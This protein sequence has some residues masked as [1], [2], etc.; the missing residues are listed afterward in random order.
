MTSGE[1]LPR[2]TG[3]HGPRPGY[4]RGGTGTDIDAAVRAVRER[5]PV[6]ADVRRRH[7][8]GDPDSRDGHDGRHQPTGS[9]FHQ[10]GWTLL[11]D[12]PA[13][14]VGR[15]VVSDGRSATKHAAICRAAPP[16]GARTSVS[17]GL[18]G[19]SRCIRHHWDPGT[20][21]AAEPHRDAP[22][23]WTASSSGRIR[24]RAGCG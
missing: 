1:Y 14:Q 6:P 24:T 13:V 5:R 22:A 18:A 23:R 17:P 15:T 4:S 16:V 19:R 3:P 12:R 21:P 7:E 20:S 8:C 10:V 9:V 11:R 2:P